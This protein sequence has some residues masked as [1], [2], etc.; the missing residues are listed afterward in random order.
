[1]SDNAATIERFY[2]AFQILDYA[3]MNAC[4]SEDI[5]F[6][7]PVFGLLRGNEVRS[8]WEMLCKNATDFSL[9]LT[10]LN[11]WMRNMVPVTG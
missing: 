9:Q 6:S 3:G 7:D 10:I 2:S 11:C 1:M 4:Y 5:A 8:M